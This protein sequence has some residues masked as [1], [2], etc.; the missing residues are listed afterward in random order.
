MASESKTAIIAAVCGNFAVAVTKFIAAGFSGSAAMVSEGIHS[1]VDTGN[2]ILLLLGLKTSKRPADEE[3]PFGHGLDLYFWTLIVS[4]LIFGVGGGVSIYEGVTHVLNPSPVEQSPWIYIALGGGVLFEGIAW[5][6][7]L[8]GFSSAMGE[9]SV[10][11]TIKR[12][13]DPTIFAVLFEDSAALLGL[14]VAFLGI[15]FGHLLGMPILDAVASIVIGVILMVVA[16]VLAWESRKLMLGESAEQETV[17]SIQSIAR[18][19]PAVEH[20]RRPL[21][22]HFGPHEILVNLD[23][24]F[25]K[26]LS[27]GEVTQ[28]V[29]RLEE[30]IRQAHPNVHRIF[31]EAGRLVARTG[32]QAS[33]PQASGPPAAG[34][35]AE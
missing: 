15:Y 4:L 5:M 23:V 14:V 31:I 3:H 24:E 34:Q 20:A 18:Q 28:A 32:P 13:K 1:V 6:F 8:K 9:R 22:M 33:G 19:D 12:T 7:A 10:W 2:G 30:K 17:G 16:S 26:A 11:Q 35:P 25:R 29:D 21:T 27:A